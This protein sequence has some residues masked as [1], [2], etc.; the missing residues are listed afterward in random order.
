MGVYPPR[1]RA[2][3]LDEG[4]ARISVDLRESEA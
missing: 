4:M 2:G 3:I 1:Q